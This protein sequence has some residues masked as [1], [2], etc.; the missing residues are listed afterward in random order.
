MLSAISM[1]YEFTL[2]QLISL[3][4]GSTFEIYAITI[5]LYTFSLG[6]GALYYEKISLKS[7]KN[8]ILLKTELGLSAVALISPF[9]I[10][11]L[12]STGALASWAWLAKPTAFAPVFLCGWLS[13]VELPCL[14]SLSKDKDKEVLFVDFLGM[15][16]GSLLFAIVLIDLMGPLSL[17]WMLSVTNIILVLLFFVF[18]KF[19]IKKIFWFSGLSVLLLSLICLKLETSIIDLFRGVHGV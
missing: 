9:L 10:V 5:G 1:L 11:V 16:V 4:F 2:A 8:S 3:F 19:R 6:V 17:I 18:K 12:S 15:F 13:G 14:L 7:N